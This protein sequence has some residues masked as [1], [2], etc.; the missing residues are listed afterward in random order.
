MHNYCHVKETQNLKDMANTII[1]KPASINTMSMFIKPAAFLHPFCTLLDDWKWEEIH[2]E[3]QPV[4]DEFGSILLLV[5][6]FR[7]RLNLRNSELGAQQGEG[8]LAKYL[9]AGQAE[10]DL[11]KLS[12]S[13]Q[14]HLGDWIKSFYIDEGLSDDLTTNCSAQ[15]FYLL[16]PTLLRQSMLAHSRARLTSDTLKAGLECMSSSLSLLSS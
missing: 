8:F 16:I 12:D 11:S 2:G 15:E 13:T 14:L 10:Q 9:A 6:A 1:R 5:L 7:Q 3:S 4:Y